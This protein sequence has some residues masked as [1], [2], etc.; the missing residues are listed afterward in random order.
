MLTLVM[1]SNISAVYASPRETER[2]MQ[3]FLQQER[4]D[5]F[6]TFE[7]DD[8]EAWK[9]K[10]GKNSDIAKIITKEKFSKFVQAR[11]LARRGSYEES[12]KLAAE[13]KDQIKNSVESH[14]LNS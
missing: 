3:N 4:E 13:L 12:V 11:R 6:Q 10:V 8:Y 5:F 1:A 9:S 2:L 7:D 14:N